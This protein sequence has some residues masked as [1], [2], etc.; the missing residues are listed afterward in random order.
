MEKPTNW[1]SPDGVQIK[2]IKTLY[3]FEGYRIDRV[4]LSQWQAQIL[5]EVDGRCQPR[6]PGC[7][8]KAALNR[9]SRS[10]AVD[11]PLGPLKKVTID[12]PVI[13]LKCSGC[14]E[15][16]SVRPPGIDEG[17]HATIRLMRAVSWACRYL[18]LDEVQ[19]LYAVSASTARR[20]DKTILLRELPQPN[21]DGLLTLLVDEKA[22]RKRHGYVTLVM[23]GETGEL[24]HM[25]EGKKKESLQQF[26]D[27]LTEEQKASIEAV[28]IDRAGAY[29]ACVKE[30]LPEA[31]IVFDKFHVVASFNS[32]LDE[33]RR[34]EWREAQAE[35]KKVVKGSRFLL[36]SN[37]ENLDGCQRNRLRELLNLNES[38]A[39]A[40]VLKDALKQLWTYIYPKAASNYLHRWCCLARDSGIEQMKKFAK[41]LMKAH[42]EIVAF[43]HYPITTAKLESF[44]AL[45]ARVVR[46]SCGVRDLEYLFLKLRQEAL[47]DSIRSADLA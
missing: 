42:D 11:L 14:G 38:L 8:E 17:A 37:T 20:Y 30:N 47:G 35:D 13:Q 7:G 24:L 12:F 6:C 2:N 21:L 39:S 4:H 26:F 41:S 36:F 22:V 10:L 46:K 40:Y 31:A 27:R 23:N 28:A 9:R 32:A 45:V 18:P 43:C 3:Q 33:L 15:C 19:E 16:N 29:L 34:K 44:N 1:E 25:A 5:L